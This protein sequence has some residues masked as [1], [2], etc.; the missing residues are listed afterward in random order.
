MDDLRSALN[1]ATPDELHDLTELLFR[2]RFNPLDYLLTPKPLDVQT[3]D[4]SEQIRVL[5]D[6]FRFLA[7]D[8][9][10]VL[11]GRAHQLDYRRILMQV[12]CYLKITYTADFTTLDL[13]AEIL[14]ALLQ[15][16]C[17]GLSP[18]QYHQFNRQLR[19]S[20]AQSDQFQGLSEG[21][22]RDPLRL[23]MTGSGVLAVSSF[24][25]P[26]LLRQITEQWTTHV[27]CGLARRELVAGTSGFLAQL[28]RRMI[29]G[30]ASRRLAVGVARASVVRGTLAVVGSLLWGWLVVD[31]GWRTIAT[32][33]S[34][35]IPFIFI[36]AQ[37][38]LTRL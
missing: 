35:V 13:E 6:R 36:L 15:R 24:L 19:S 4:R 34:R 25:R 31:L 11:Q 17:T 9:F 21:D 3:Y 10:T 22:R 8:G 5:E 14:L 18:T 1:L 20:L 30:G 27:A 38:R 2:P 16:A 26:W 28:P 7:A 32:N 12:C 29:L 33:Y 37:I 23:L